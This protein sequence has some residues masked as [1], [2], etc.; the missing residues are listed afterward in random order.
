[1]IKEWIIA[2]S[3]DRQKPLIE[4]LLSFRGITKKEDA[5]NFLNPLEIPLCE[6]NVFVDMEKAVE[7]TALA[8]DK[9]EN[10]LVYGDF[11]ADGVTS[12]SLLI[13]TLQKTGA[14][15]DYYIPDREKE[16]HGLNSKSLVKLMTS[17][18][19]KLLITCDNG[20]S[21]IEEITFLNS[22]KIDVIITDHH[23]A[24]EKLPPAYAIIN[25]KAPDAL[26]DTLSAGKI[27]EL[28][29]LAGVGVAFKF[30]QALLIHFEK[31][32]FIYELLPFVAVGTIA[33]IVPLIG[34]NRY[35]VARGMDLI[36]QG[37]HYGITKLL[38]KCGCKIENEIKADQ[39]A[40]QLAPRINASGRL[41]NVENALKVMLSDNKQEIAIAIESLQE[42]NRVRQELCNNTVLEAEEMLLNQD[43]NANSIILFNPKWHIGI[44]GIVASKLVEKYYK[45][46]FLITYHEESKQYRCSARSVKGINLY[47][48]IDANSEMLDGF[49]G[50][51]MAAGLSFSEDKIS[52][53]KLK[54]DLNN[55]INEILNGKQLKPFLNIDM[56][57]N[58]EE[59]TIGLVDEISKLEPFG[60]G[61][62]APVFVTKNLVLKEKK[63]MGA[64]KEHLK[65]I[66]QENDNLLTAIWWSKGDIPL[67]A[68]DNL[69][70]AYSPQINVFNGTTSLQLILQDIHSE[71]LVEEDSED[72]SKIKIYDHRKKTDILPLVE[73]YISTSKLNI[74]VFCENNE[75]VEYLKPYKSISESLFTRQSIQQADAVMFF[76]YPC[77][78]SIF[79]QI[80]KS[81]STKTLHYMHYSI[82]SNEEKLIKKILG[83]VNYVCNKKQG[84]FD[85]MS[86]ACFLSQ[87]KTLIKSA[88]EL[89]ADCSI[90]DILN[91][92]ENQYKLAFLKNIE[93]SNIKKCE[94]YK[95][96]L[97][98]VD[99]IQKYRENLCE[100]EICKL[101]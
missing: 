3:N 76:D 5:K 7:R 79:E 47:D 77:E 94:K 37:K 81:T 87:T 14:N 100:N 50:H 90:I 24:G 27:Q 97:E 86:S 43:N 85:L 28:A 60:A 66:L 57:L 18:K 95:E 98:I 63:F 9:G 21:N 72:N 71:N 22:F 34:E 61:N 75:I 58:P 73:D 84:E 56:E 30:A 35:F 41:E 45:P 12:T 10:I 31:Q 52:F 4:R 78:E 26:S 23:E 53:E 101:L 6:P 15:V 92:S 80:L 20:I 96:F 40:F 36:S 19:P 13:K 88:L 51:E 70:I 42:L 91:K 49:G 46:T 16:G 25:P 55:T 48:V 32:D 89:F 69:D 33:D 99:S 2:G 83:M 68:G 67:L 44:I 17:K 29:A 1:M 65:L 8:I 39:I 54:D 59:L 93:L 82:E 64:N 38:E 11:D 62:P 74:R